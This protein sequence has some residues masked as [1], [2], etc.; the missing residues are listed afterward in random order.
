MT[1]IPAHTLQKRNTRA[2]GQKRPSQPR[3]VVRVSLFV[4][5]CGEATAAKPP[6]ASAEKRSDDGK[7]APR[8]RNGHAQQPARLS[9]GFFHAWTWAQSGCKMGA[10]WVQ[11]TFKKNRSTPGHTGKGETGKQLR[12]LADDRFIGMYGLLG[13]LGL[14]DASKPYISR[15]TG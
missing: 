7:Y 11:K 12:Q 2:D 10:K 9:G 1:A 8:S 14:L 4:L 15:V 6:P 5:R 3:E 13:L